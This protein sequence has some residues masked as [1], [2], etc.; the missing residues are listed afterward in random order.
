MSRTMVGLLAAAGSIMSALVGLTHGD[1]VPVLI[2]GAGTAGGLAA[3]LALSSQKN[4]CW[5][6]FPRLSR[7]ASWE[8][9]SRRDRPTPR[10]RN[11]PRHSPR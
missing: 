2:A 8:V 5:V 4:P 10:A 11:R 9:T 7:T 6:H 1:L 3:Y